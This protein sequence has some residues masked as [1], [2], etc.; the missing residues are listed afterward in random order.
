MYKV[1][2]S[3]ALQILSF[4]NLPNILHLRGKDN[5]AEAKTSDIKPRK[6]PSDFVIVS[7]VVPDVILEIRYYSGF[8][9]IGKRFPLYNSP[10]A[11][12]TKEAANALKKANDI[13]KSQGYILKIWDAYRPQ[14]SVNYIARWIKDAGDNKMKEFFYPDIDKKDLFELGYIVKHSGHSR[15]STVDLT[16]VDMKTGKEIDMGSPFDFFGEISHHGTALISKDQEN[17]R[18]I[19]KEAMEAAGFDFYCSEWWHYTL[20]DEP[21][22][23]DYFDFEINNYKSPGII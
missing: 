16:I 14:S 1:R 9:F 19:L 3:G 21:Y 11:I 4:F 6:I 15:G 17:N 22:S 7:D 2:C 18:Q 12:L 8:N 20:K 23:D 13:L 10:V 5:K